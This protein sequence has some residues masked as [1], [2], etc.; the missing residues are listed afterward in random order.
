[1]PHVQGCLGPLPAIFNKQLVKAS[2]SVISYLL[3]AEKT[4]KIIQ[5]MISPKG[6]AVI[7]PMDDIAEYVHHW[8]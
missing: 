2:Q 4:A 1:M 5:W 7:Y 3:K 8:L 6:H